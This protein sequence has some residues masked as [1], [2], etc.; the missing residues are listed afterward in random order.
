MTL[1]KL[2]ACC[3]Q[4]RKIQ[5]SGSSN[6]NSTFYVWMNPKRLLM[7]FRGHPAVKQYTVG[8]M[9]FRTDA[10][11]L[12]LKSDA[13]NDT[14]SFV[15]NKLIPFMLWEVEHWRT[16]VRSFCE[17]YN[18]AVAAW[19]LHLVTLRYCEVLTPTQK[20]RLRQLR[21][22]CQTWRNPEFSVMSDLT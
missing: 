14:R 7:R 21:W 5:K 16:P 6:W 15:L 17:F 22:L 11:S 8:Y 3:R 18:Q 2:L 12:A 13:P 19:V 4:N 20:F 1:R 10:R 9:P